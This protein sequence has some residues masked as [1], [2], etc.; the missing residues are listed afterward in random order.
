MLYLNPFQLVP[1]RCESCR[2]NFCLK[3]RHE[4]DHSCSA[5]VRGSAGRLVFSLNFFI[6]IIIKSRTNVCENEKAVRAQTVCKL[7][8]FLMEHFRL[9]LGNFNVHFGAFIAV[10]F[11]LIFL[12]Q[13]KFQVLIS[14]CLF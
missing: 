12:G 2:Q 5:V 8:N 3:H 1:V 6:L 4:Q 7:I 13:S 9:N 10:F 11:Q 14:S